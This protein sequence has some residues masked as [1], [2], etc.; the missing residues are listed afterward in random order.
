MV[1]LGV[2]MFC[3]F[4]ITTGEFVVAGILPAVATDLQVTVGTAGLLVTAYAVGMILG[5]PVLT[6]LTAGTD[7]K[8]LMLALLA[9]AVAG[10]AIS[11]LAPG[12][13]LLLAARVATALVT[14][15]FF[16][17]AIVIAVRSAPP[18]RAATM[19]ARLAFGMNLAI[20]LGAPIGTQ[21]GGHWGWRATFAAI[22]VACLIGFG[23]VLLLLTTPPDEHRRSAVSELRVLR[24]R[25]VLIALAITAVGNVGVLMV[26]SYLAPLLTNLGGHPATRLPVLL[27]AYGVGATIGNLLGGAL[28]DRNPRVSQPALLGALAAAL[29]GTWFV[30]GSTTLTAVAV[31]VIGLLAFA[32]IPG[33]QAR[34]MTTA[35]EAPTLAVAVNA[36]GYQL[37]AACAGLFGGLIADS[38]AGPRPIYLTAAVLTTCALLITLVATRSPRTT[39]ATPV[40]QPA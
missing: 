15:T 26:F 22:A 6:A 38:T 23:L 31:V 32:I 3:V 18:E 1:R 34:V 28:Y 19:V 33:M 2:L 29:V 25:P 37:A 9:V 40:D 4:G 20:I 10:N 30:A 39:A 8:R 35:T 12:F 5:G 7:R 17:Q 21:I 36:S 24:R 11:A 14:S 27:L 13:S 16:A